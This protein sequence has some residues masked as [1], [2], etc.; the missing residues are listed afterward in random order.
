MSLGSLVGKRFELLVD[1]CW[2]GV[3]K[4]KS[5]FIQAGS[6]G[7]VESVTLLEGTVPLVYLNFD[8]IKPREGFVF[9]LGCADWE[10][11]TTRSRRIKIHFEEAA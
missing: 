1:E 6:K 2:S 11:T 10:F 7:V 5:Y 3:P 4:G 8:Q 9:G